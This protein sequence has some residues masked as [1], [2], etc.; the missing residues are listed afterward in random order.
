MLRDPNSENRDV[1]MLGN[2]K[3]NYTSLYDAQMHG[4]RIDAA[5]QANIGP[6]GIEVQSQGTAG[7]KRFILGNRFVLGAVDLDA[8]LKMPID[9]PFYFDTPPDIEITAG[10][11]I[12]RFHDA[13]PLAQAIRIQNTFLDQGILL[14]P[15]T[16]DELQHIA[17]EI[18]EPKPTI[19]EWIEALEQIYNQSGLA[20]GGTLGARALLQLEDILLSKGDA[21]LC[22]WEV[23]GSVGFSFRGVPARNIRENFVLNGNLAFAPDPLTQW[24]F[25]LRVNSGF[26]LLQMYSV[27]TTASLARRVS[28]TLRLKS[29]AAFTREPSTQFGHE[30]TDRLAVSGTALFQLSNRINLSFIGETAYQTGQDFNYWRL[31]VQFS[32]DFFE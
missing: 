2:F 19:G 18:N 30:F 27:R 13:T 28:K 32:Y 17:Q 3:S 6:N 31:A 14:G 11:G 24:T 8:T 1:S 21:R 25:G 12:G 16:D 9:A 5:G 29:S 23:E 22:G 20:S 15:L 7:F 10:V 4:Y 26:N